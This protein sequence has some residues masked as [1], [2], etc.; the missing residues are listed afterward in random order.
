MKY[1]SSNLLIRF[2]PFKY[3]LMEYSMNIFSELIR[4]FVKLVIFIRK[5]QHFRRWKLVL[6]EQ[7]LEVPQSHKLAW[8]FPKKLFLVFLHHKV[9][10]SRLTKNLVNFWFFWNRLLNMMNILPASAVW[11][12]IFCCDKEHNQ[13]YLAFIYHNPCLSIVGLIT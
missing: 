2:S 11:I 6:E 13:N 7:F 8:K 4:Y 5:Y 12:T 9:S 3:G 10:F 1:Y